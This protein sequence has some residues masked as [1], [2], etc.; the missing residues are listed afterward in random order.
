MKK[1]WDGV[2]YP[3]LAQTHYVTKTS[4]KMLELKELSQ[5]TLKNI[6]TPAENLGLITSTI[7]MEVCDHP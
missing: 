6:A 2:P 4:S 3:R 1:F 7:H 5:L